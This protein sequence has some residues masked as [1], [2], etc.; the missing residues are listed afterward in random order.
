MLVSLIFIV[1]GLD[2]EP[3][4]PISWL[5]HACPSRARSLVRGARGCS[6]F[7]TLNHVK[8]LGP[9]LE[10]LLPPQR[11]R[12]AYERM[13]IHRCPGKGHL[14]AQPEAGPGMEDTRDHGVSNSVE[15]LPLAKLALF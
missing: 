2:M 13:Y 9:E 6:P 8:E 4:G 12:S 5:S 10:L 1:S 15:D 14:L 7:R 3:V 11:Q